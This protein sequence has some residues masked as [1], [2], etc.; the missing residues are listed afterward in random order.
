MLNQEIKDKIFKKAISLEK[1]GI[2]DLA[3]ERKD[4]KSLIQEIINDKIGILGGDIY[5][6]SNSHLDALSDN[7][8]CE[9]NETE[10]EEKYYFRSK[11]E[12]LKYI[13]EYPVQR[14]EHILFSI[15]FTEKII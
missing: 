11:I 14:E 4:I 12:S 3:W 2:N 1:Y 13:K 5:K 8:A 7:W 15:T 10:S 6:I 9:P